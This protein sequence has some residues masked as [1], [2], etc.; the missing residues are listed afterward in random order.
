MVIKGDLHVLCVFAF[1]V[2]CLAFRCVLALLAPPTPTA[3]DS[4]PSTPQHTMPAPLSSAAGT[5]LPSCPPPSQQQQ[6]P[7]AQVG[8]EEDFDVD[9]LLLSSPA[10]MLAEEEQAKGSGGPPTF[11]LHATGSHFGGSAH[12]HSGAADSI[13]STHHSSRF[14]QFA[15]MD[16]GPLAVQ[17]PPLSRALSAEPAAPFLGYLVHACLAASEVEMA[18]GGGAGGNRTL[19]LMA[20]QL[21]R[22]LM[23]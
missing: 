23:Q 12:P 21:L 14:S 11:G 15:G 4:V 22:R 10:E 16:S 18:G 9:A 1:Q 5:M 8:A 20:L 3:A 13:R 17:V 7:S 2:R 6:Q 19:R